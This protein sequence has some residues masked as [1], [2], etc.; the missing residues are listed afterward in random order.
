M[1]ASPCD[2]ANRLRR[3]SILPLQAS[4]AENIKVR[5]VFPDTAGKQD[6][7]LYYTFRDNS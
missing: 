3:S 4:A 5:A 6:T 1:T 2:R 7:F